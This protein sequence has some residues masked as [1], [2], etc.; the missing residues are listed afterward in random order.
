MPEPWTLWK[1]SNQRN[2]QKWCRTNTHRGSTTTYSSQDFA[3][4]SWVMGTWQDDFVVVLV[5]YVGNRQQQST[6][7]HNLL[8]RWGCQIALRRIGAMVSTMKFVCSWIG[9]STAWTE[10]GAPHGRHLK[11]WRLHMWN[12]TW[13][14]EDW[15]YPLGREEIGRSHSRIT[16]H[17]LCVEPP[18]AAQ[19]HITM[20]YR[21]RL[22]QPF[23]C[24]SWTRPLQA[25][26]WGLTSS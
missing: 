23:P 7:R 19:W 9:E 4:I 21:G 1:S 8:D 24:I 2:G 6:T 25:L 15:C 3:K 26:G 11:S 18:W 14:P 12:H 20:H 5:P 17:P 22:N 13:L 10:S 16:W